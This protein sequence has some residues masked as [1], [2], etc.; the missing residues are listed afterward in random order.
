MGFGG[1]RLVIG[2]ERDL[3]AI[4]DGKIGNSFVA[5]YRFAAGGAPPI[6]FRNIDLPAYQIP[7]LQVQPAAGREERKAA[8]SQAFIDFADGLVR[9]YNAGAKPEAEEI[10]RELRARLD[11]FYQLYA[12]L[13]QGR[14]N[15]SKSAVKTAQDV[16]T[17][18]QIN[19]STI[20]AYKR[21]SSQ[22]IDDY[23]TKFS[24]TLHITENDSFSLGV[25][26]VTLLQTLENDK[27]QEVNDSF[28]NLERHHRFL[29]ENAIPNSDAILQKLEILAVKKT[30]LD[31][32]SKAFTIAKQRI[33]KAFLIISETPTVLRGIISSGDLK[34]HSTDDIT[35]EVSAKNPVIDSERENIAEASREIIEIL[36]SFVGGNTDLVAQAFEICDSMDVINDSIKAIV[37]NFNACKACTGTLDVVFK[38]LAAYNKTLG[39]ITFQQDH[40]RVIQMQAARFLQE[41][42]A[43]NAREQERRNAFNERE[44][45]DFPILASLLRK[46]TP[47]VNVSIYSYPITDSCV[48]DFDP[49]TIDD[50]G[51]LPFRSTEIAKKLASLPNTSLV[52]TAESS[53]VPDDIN[54]SDTNATNFGTSFGG[55]M[56]TAIGSFGS[57]PSTI[58]SSDASTSASTSSSS[59]SSEVLSPPSFDDPNIL[60]VLRTRSVGGSLVQ[61]KAFNGLYELFVKHIEA[62]TT[63]LNTNGPNDAPKNLRDLI[64]TAQALISNFDSSSSPSSSSSP[65]FLLPSSPNPNDQS[66]LDRLTRSIAIMK[67]QQELIDSLLAQ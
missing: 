41:C 26:D 2:F 65:L 55:P 27:L 11:A 14:Q 47:T 15:L 18:M 29:E 35:D 66:L 21:V 59:S 5:P 58:F 51:P 7:L 16:K 20:D 38:L 56:G 34:G 22:L 39:E 10:S 25:R 31:E 54:I 12:F 3:T 24:T 33:D 60:K 46:S 44:C 4:N 62:A 63:A 49:V 1:K 61:E 36:N 57:A 8:F 67:N 30:Q 64:E 9:D 19:I 13:V 43:R 53:S 52:I 28:A 17:Q 50:K 45:R 37:D 32:I 23:L 6:V 48:C 42:S 40:E